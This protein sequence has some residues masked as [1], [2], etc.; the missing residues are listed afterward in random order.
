M[1]F[2]WRV[3]DVEHPSFPTFSPGL[4]IPTSRSFFRFKSWD[5][6]NGTVQSW[7]QTKLKTTTT[8]KNCCSN[9]RTLNF[10]LV[11]STV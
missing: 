7:D 4:I 10:I 5:R 3:E 8:N 11:D 9:P 1:Y 6:I 2:I